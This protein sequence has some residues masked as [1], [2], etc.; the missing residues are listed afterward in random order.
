[1]IFRTVVELGGKTATG[2]EVPAEVVSALGTTKQPPVRVTINGHSYRTTVAPMG[3]RFLIPL[4][5]QN[6]TAAGVAAGEAIDV[7]IEPDNA[8]REVTVPEDLTAALDAEPAAR[9]FF[10]SLS[11][12]NKRFH[13]EQVEGAKSEA[14][15]RR[16]I[17]KSVAILRVGKAR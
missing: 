9:A 2:F 16:R 12:S 15:R 1:M 6:R 5:A 3:G 8:P 13:V 17:E 14:T 7:E 4:S 11:Y 10:E